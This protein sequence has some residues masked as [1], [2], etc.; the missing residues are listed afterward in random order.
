MIVS[1][2]CIRDMTEKF[3]Q[4]GGGCWPRKFCM[5]MA[6]PSWVHTYGRSPLTSASIGGAGESEKNEQYMLR[7]PQGGT[8]GCTGSSSQAHDHSTWGHRWVWR[9]KRLCA[10]P[11]GP[12]E[13][14]S[15]QP[16]L[17]TGLLVYRSQCSGDW[18]GRNNHLVVLSCSSLGSYTESRDKISRKR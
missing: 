7:R 13:D 18:M 15:P 4:W 2:D 9:H 8:A 1:H 16:P 11:A 12:V 17:W 5:R 10:C 3:C 6:P 14:G